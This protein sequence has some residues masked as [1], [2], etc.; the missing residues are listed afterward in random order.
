MAEIDREDVPALLLEMVPEAAEHI[1]GLYEMPAVEAVKTEHPDVDTFDLL[2]DALAQPI[3]IPQLRSETPNADLLQRCFDYTELLVKSPS[4]S[5]R[6][7]AYFQ[8]LEALLGEDVPYAKA[9]PYM[10]PYTRQQALK[11]L[12]HYAV[13]RPEGAES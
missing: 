6:E 12:D 10:R 11:M 4:S 8:I 9:F 13:E 2:G 3:I 7:G 1:A 5:L